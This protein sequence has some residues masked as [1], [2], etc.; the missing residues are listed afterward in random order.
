MVEIRRADL[1]DDED[2]RAVVRLTD[3]YARDPMGGGDPL[4]D[5]V[6]DRLVGA[7]REHGGV[8]VLLAEAEEGPVGLV[9]VV[10]KFSTF[11][12][13]PTLN[14]HDVFVEGP[15]RGEGI[16]AAL[17]AAVEELARGRGCARV[18]LEVLEEN[19]AR[20]LYQRAG[21]TPRS[22]YWVKRLDE[23]GRG[24]ASPG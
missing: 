5:S 22:E 15:R 4:P 23:E 24:Y 16:G 6:K 2:A 12:A 20:R 7:M 14:V 8:E 10:F 3:A 11:E 9:T 1:E 21:Y 18:N 13:A 17:L 19:P